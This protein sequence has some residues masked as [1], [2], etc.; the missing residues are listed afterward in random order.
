VTLWDTR[1]GS[2]IAT[3]QQLSWVTAL[4]FNPDRTIL[5]TGHDDGRVRLW[6]FDSQ[7]LIVE[8]RDHES[9]I[10]ALAFSADGKRLAT[11][12]ED[13]AIHIIDM[14]TRNKVKS[15]TGHTDRVPA[16]AW[17]PN[18]NLLASAGWDTTAR[19]WDVARGEPLMLL[20]SHSDQ[21]LTLA[22]NHD[23]SLLACADSDNVIHVWDNPISGRTLSVL[24]GHTDE[25]R[26]LAFSPDG[27]RLASAGNDQAVH[28]W[29]PRAG[30]LLAGQNAQ[31]L[32]AI[33]VAEKRLASNCG[34][35]SLE[36]Y[37]LETGKAI[38]PSGAAVPMIA[39]RRPEPDDLSTRKTGTIMPG[40]VALSPDARTLVAGSAD[41][42][43]HIWDLSTNEPPKQVR[44]SWGPVGNIAFSPDCKLFASAC[45]DDGT[46]WLWSMETQ[47]VFLLI[48]E[49]T[50]GCSV[51]A[52]AFHPNNR[53]LA[54][55]GIDWLSTRGSD[56][57]ICMWD[58]VDRQRLFIFEGGVSSLAFHPNGRWLAGAS[59][60][61]EQVTLWDVTDAQAQVVRLAGHQ[62]R[63]RAVAFS[64][65]GKWL[66]SAGD[67][68]TLRVWHG[69]SFEEVGAWQFDAPI[70]ALAFSPD[71]SSL[72]LA[73]ANTTC[74]EIA[75]EELVQDVNE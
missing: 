15:L 16:I 28:I 25:I 53:W 10:S 62:E 46:C 24:E 72:F 74:S 36:L 9:P 26:A 18:G 19:L 30:R 1:D 4:A 69:E 14:A 27:Q 59:L 75:F 17:H 23:G 3:I 50:D 12:G 20:N 42:Y 47:D 41:S 6:N 61:D 31:S 39:A 33:S 44:G 64:P 11:A 56:G 48:P 54:C 8:L 63:V 22:F 40:G 55:G 68:R 38:P 5:A 65:N 21:V 66:V 52:V 43:L 37:N 51:D 34:G 7:A 67:D 29:D 49:A 57:A 60:I 58:V 32:H 70:K 35:T 71:G 2:Q 13:R 45:A 73:N